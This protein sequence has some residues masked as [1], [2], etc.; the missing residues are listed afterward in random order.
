MNK[1]PSIIQNNLF[2]SPLIK[3]NKIPIRIEGN[4]PVG[5][6][7]K[8]GARYLFI[9]NDQTALTH[10]LHKYPAKFFPELPRWIIL[11]YSDTGDWVLDPFTGSGTVNLECLI[12][13]RNSVGIDID[14]FARFLTKVKLT[15]LDQYQLKKA[16]IWIKNEIKKFDKEKPQLKEFPEFPYRDNWFKPYIL[17]ELTYIRKKIYALKDKPLRDLGLPESMKITNFFLV[18]FSSII[19]SV[20]NADDNCTRTVIRRRLN[21]QVKKYDALKK[22][23]AAIDFNVPKMEQFSGI[24]S[25]GIKVDIPEDQDARDIKYPDNSFDLV[26]TS[27]PYVNAVDY[28]RT[29]QL[30]M[31]WL[32]IQNGSLTPLKKLH[33]GTESV[34]SA[35]Y[36]NLHQ[37]GYPESN[38]VIKK[39][40]NRDKRRA[41]IVYKYLVDIKKNLE[42]VYRVLKPTRKYVLVVGNN[43]IRGETVENWKYFMEIGRDVGFKV[44][45]YFASEIIRHFIKV[46]RRE[47]IQADWVLILEK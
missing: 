8:K 34:I 29:H 7:I 40:Y 46:P 38:R 22:F 1:Q 30:E 12:L 5:L 47:R 33:V 18:C 2:T 11:K 43:Q 45:N 10:G 37:L 21:K 32:G 15:P 13:K 36:R 20:S 41:F 42:E 31:Y 17:E 23:E 16:Y 4:I 19:R 25:S 44:R 6:K 26:V 3:V 35:Q 39:I 24:V 9:S 27:P 14:P 28:P